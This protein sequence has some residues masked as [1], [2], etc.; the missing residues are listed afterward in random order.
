MRTVTIS[1]GG[2]ADLVVDR[3]DI[4]GDNYEVDPTGFTVEAGSYHQIEITYDPTTFEH[5]E[6]S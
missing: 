6:G 3:L 2:T 1:N 5:N 4:Q